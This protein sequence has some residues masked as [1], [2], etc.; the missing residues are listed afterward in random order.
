MCLEDP[1]NAVLSL[2][3]FFDV[4][5]E[6]LVS[7]TTPGSIPRGYSTARTRASEISANADIS[8]GNQNLTPKESAKYEWRLDCTILHERLP[9]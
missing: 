9:G 7:E 8:A 5:I 4:S 3:P 2:V 6:A 1:A